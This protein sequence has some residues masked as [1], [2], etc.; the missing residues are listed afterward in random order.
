MTLTE[1]RVLGFWVLLG[2]LIIN[3]HSYGQQIP[4]N[5]D[6]AQLQRMTQG[7]LSD[8]EVENLTDAQLQEFIQQ[9]ESQGMSQ[10]QIESM[11]R[12]QGL[13][14]E[15]IQRL[16][17]RLQNLNQGD[18][19]Q[20]LRSRRS[21]ADARESLSPQDQL[22]SILQRD[23]ELQ[24]QLEFQARIFGYSLFQNADLTFEPSLN[25]ATP[26]NYKIGPGDEIV[27]DIW[28][29]SEAN[30]MLTVSPEGYVFVK[31]LGPIYINGLN[32]DV[33]S[34]RI[35]D[36]LSNIYSGL[37]GSNPN[38]FA[39]VSLGSVRSIKV[40]ILGEVNQPG[41]Y[42]LNS[43][44]TVFNALYASGG[45]SI[46]GSF[47]N[48]EI[49]RNNMVINVLDIYDFL[50]DGSQ[51]NNI[52]LEDQDVVRVTPYLNRVEII[53]EVKR[54]EEVYELQQGEDVADLIRY[55]GGFT[56]KAYSHS[57][58]IRRNTERA[59]KVIDVDQSE[60][61]EFT[62]QGGDMV[63]V[64]PIL[65]RFDNRV[66]ITGAVF[67]EG[68]YEL[69]DGMSLNDL[70][71]KSEGLRGDAFMERGTIYRTNEDFST[72]VIPFNVREIL[73]GADQDILLHREDLVKISSI[74]DL[75]EEFFVQIEGEV[76]ESGTFPFMENMTI[77]DLIM[78]AGGLM[79][80]ASNSNVE[81][82]RRYKPANEDQV[83]NRVAQIYTFKVSE[84]LTMEEADLNFTLQPFDM[85]FIRRSPGYQ[86]QQTVRIEGEVLYPGVYGIQSKNERISDLIARAGGLTSEAYV[87]GATFRRR[88]R[89]FDSE[90]EDKMRR[91]KLR[92][93]KQR[94]LG[95]NDIAFNESER[96]RYERI[97]RIQIQN[98]QN[99]SNT[100]T[101]RPP[102][103]PMY[104]NEDSLIQTQTYVV[105]REA[106]GIRLNE[107]L[108]NPGTAYD[109]FLQ[110]GDVLRIPK[111]LQTVKLEGELLYPITVRYDNNRG[112]MH[113]VSQAGGFT[114]EAQKKK[115]YVV[116]ANG[117]VDRTRNFLFFRNYPRIEPGAQIIVP[118]QPPKNPMGVQ[119]WIAVSSSLASLGL[120]I[121][122][123]AN[124]L[125]NQ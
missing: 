61:E 23:Y 73:K 18:Y 15:Q 113:Y 110:D 76:Q 19:E 82:A 118:T 66:Q 80:S 1:K 75:N 27:I 123:L 58:K 98:Q 88:Q 55:A 56:D 33:A 65:N 39:Q 68:E 12:Q 111:E 119:G 57:L 84:N 96:L 107:I 93:L 95:N 59:R 7:R 116:Y 69:E 24:K 97:R 122:T 21:S 48:V 40:T 85:V 36:R 14:Q 64:E 71:Q 51:E 44:A 25:I 43:L 120:L 37:R 49:V 53:G 83:S 10:A 90:E 103:D 91:D 94:N 125:S 117:A 46:N 11:L 109:L 81:V 26:A 28:G 114:T 108:E 79:E 62:M 77:E 4:G 104:L 54:D 31:N 121:V 92:Q 67:R 32:M 3:N 9:A 100:E 86:I 47:R 72:E 41:T 45:P 124:N 99:N 78:Q 6:P 101:N 22:L 16:R 52:R 34:A 29:A 106:I 38:T 60:F 115:A 13:S 5:Q 8:L 50:V 112:F 63:N 35:K 17:G 30:Y 2:F 102:Y 70:L 20:Y 87:E 74:Y 89:V 42:T 105:E